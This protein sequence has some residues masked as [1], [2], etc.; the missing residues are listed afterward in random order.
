MPLCRDPGLLRPLLVSSLPQAQSVHNLAFGTAGV[1]PVR[2]RVDSLENPRAVLCRTRRFALFAADAR[3]AAR[4]IAETPR[5]MRLRFG[6]TPMRFYRLIKRHWR[7]PDRGRRAWLNAC[8]MYYLRPERLVIDRSHRVT[9]LGPA[10]AA[11]IR[12]YWPYGRSAEHL[13]RRIAAGP[14]CGIRQN[15]RLV[16]WGLTH[17][18]GSMGFLHVLKEFRGRGMARSITTAL[19]G[20]LLRLGATPFLYI[21]KKNRPSISLT[22]SMGFERVGEYGWFATD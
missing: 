16:A 19:A 11:G 15:G 21:V 22:E 5:N 14:S 7:G 2:L 8:Y 10:D 9:S 1:Q 18:D 6:S 12:N 13:R 20:R 3:A 17:D 4:V